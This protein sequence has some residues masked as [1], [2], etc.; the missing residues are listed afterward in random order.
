MSKMVTSVQSSSAISPILFSPPRIEETAPKDLCVSMLSPL[1]LVEEEWR[2]SGE[3]VETG[4]TKEPLKPYYSQGVEPC[5]MIAPNALETS[6]HRYLQTPCDNANGVAAI[7]TD[8]LTTMQTYGTFCHE[9]RPNFMPIEEIVSI[10]S[11]LTTEECRENMTNVQSILI[12][13]KK[14]I[15]AHFLIKKEV[16]R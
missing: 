1:L 4:R 12:I 3:T 7:G 10:R 13:V 9:N 11:L 6:L 16:K 15:L 14:S 2:N 5:G 8:A